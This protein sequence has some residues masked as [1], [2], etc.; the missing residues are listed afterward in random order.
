MNM[1]SKQQPTSTEGAP[2]WMVS[3]ADMIT[4]IMAFF[5]VMYSS[6]GTAS[7]GKN[8]G[9]KTGQGTKPDAAAVAAKGTA[10]DGKLGIAGKSDDEKQIN[11][12]MESLRSRFGSEWTATNCW[13]GGPPALRADRR[14]ADQARVWQQSEGE[15]RLG[16]DRR[17]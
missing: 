2:E 9:E 16:T 3:Y 15:A 6:A 11:R 4:I 1:S 13:L 17:R 7:S 8:R 14:R 10:G 12:V 5:V